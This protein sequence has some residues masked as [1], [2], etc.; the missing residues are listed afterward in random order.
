MLNVLVIGIRWRRFLAIVF[1]L[2]FKILL[3]LRRLF[4]LI[5]FA[6][7]NSHCCFL[8]V[9]GKTIDDWHT[10]TYEWNTDDIRVHTSDIR[11]T[12]EYMR[13][14]YGWHTSTYEWH[15]DDIRVHTIYI[16]MTREWHTDDMRLERKIKLSFLKLFDN[17]LSKYL[18]CKRIPCMQWLLWVTYQN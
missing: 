4:W 2:L 1:P 15:T 10:S 3:D 14:T 17:S 13:V 12:Y 16:R 18:I 8:R 9:H 5:I 7:S 6:G 11:M